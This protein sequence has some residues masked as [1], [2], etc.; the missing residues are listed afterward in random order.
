MVSVKPRGWCQRNEELAAA[1]IWACISHREVAFV[2][3]SQAFAE[4]IS[5]L[6]TRATHTS[7][8][9]V[10]ALNH[11]TINNAVEDNTIIKFLFN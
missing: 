5:N 2:I 1:G 3:M 6:V 10:S 11:K 8:S 7:T 9:R 4:F